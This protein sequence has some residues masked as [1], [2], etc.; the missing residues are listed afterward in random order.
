MVAIF[1]RRGL[2]RRGHASPPIALAGRFQQAA[3]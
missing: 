1:C 2:R 3:I